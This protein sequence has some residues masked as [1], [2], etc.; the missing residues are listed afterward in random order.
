MRLIAIKLAGFKSFVE[1]VTLPVTGQMVGVVGP[2]GCGKSNVIDAVRW[3]LGESQARQLRGA[4]MA[5]VIFNGSAQRKAISR[6]SVELV[7]DNSTGRAFGN[8]SQYA[9]ISV[10]RVVT[11]QGDSTYYI[12]Q[13]AVRRRDVVDVFLGTG[14][15]GKSSYAIIEQGMITRIIE[16]RPEELRAFLEEAAGISRYKDRRRETE[17]RLEATRQNLLRVEDI[18]QTLL[19]QME[20]L[21]E[22]AETA[23]QWQQWQAELTQT[24]QLSWL[25]KQREA[26]QE[27]DRLVVLKQNV[28]Q[29]LTI[30]Q[31]A[32]QALAHAL[33]QLMQAQDDANAALNV[34]QAAFYAAGSDV[35]A[36]EQSLRH[37]QEIRTRVLA[38][39]EQLTLQE[40]AWQERQ[41][42]LNRD[43]E[44]HETQRVALQQTLTEQRERVQQQQAVL[45][46][47]E[48]AVRSARADVTERQRE[49]AAA[50]KA[51]E[52]AEAQ[53]RMLEK[54]RLQHEAQQRR[55][56]EEETRWQGAESGADLSMMQQHLALVKDKFAQLEAG[57]RTIQEELAALASA[58]DKV[59]LQCEASARDVHRLEGELAALR[60]LE[61]G[62]IRQEVAQWLTKHGLAQS[63][64]LLQQLEV[65]PG[66]ETALEQA[67]TVWLQTLLLERHNIPD[68]APQG[69]GW[70]DIAAGIAP[71]AKETHD[72]TTPDL[73]T[74]A[75]LVR[76]DASLRLLIEDLLHHCYVAETLSEARQLR[77]RLPVG[78]RLFTRQGHVLTQGG[79]QFP[80]LA[81]G[82]GALARQKALQQMEGDL[83]VMREIWQ[84][85]HRQQAEFDAHRAE[86]ETT[87]QD[88]L[89][90][91]RQAQQQ[92]HQQQLALQKTQ[93]QAE[94]RDLRLQQLHGERILVQQA[95]DNTLSEY[96]L[97]KE[98]RETQQASLA[99]HQQALRSAQTRLRENEMRQNEARTA[100]AQQEKLVQESH[101]QQRLEE[102]RLAE[103]QRSLQ[104]MAQQR[105]EHLEQRKQLETEQQ[106]ENDADL[107]MRLQQAL[108]QRQAAEQSLG[109]ARLQSEAAT[110]TWRD[111]EESR[112]VCQQAILPLQAQ[113]EQL[114]LQQQACRMT[115]EQS[116]Q[117]LA[118]LA[119]EI[120]LLEPLLNKAREPALNSQIKRLRSQ[121]EALGA[122]NLAAV[123]ELEAAR[124]RAEYLASQT[125]DLETGM[126]TLEAVIQ[127][128]DEETN[129]LFQ[130]T[131]D[132]VN[133]SMGELFQTL[134]GGGQAKLTLTDGSWLEAGVE[135][136]AQPPGKKNS[137]I[138]LLSG[139]E[140]T[141]TALS[142]VFALFKLNPAPFCLL[143]EVDAPLDDSNTER[144]VRLI[145]D[146][147][148]QTQFLF[149]THNRMTMEAAQQLLGVT[150]QEPGVSRIVAVDLVDAARMVQQ[151]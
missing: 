134:F 124:E 107:S 128:L 48:Q 25:L 12:N 52:L 29:T 138:Q 125:R 9:E 77:Y 116:G 112:L 131:F 143:D 115:A 1:P 57:G 14:L 94:H 71:V 3:A 44:I 27:H 121:I 41:A 144:Y 132:T 140:K 16:A 146:M 84:Q 78:G 113:L 33:P 141:L 83:A 120:S 108:V 122:V 53:L 91:S 68:E 67:L 26:E 130:Q 49:V 139:G 11:R 148:Q 72:L 109:K 114:V 34:A 117:M 74:L 36:L 2:N 22:Q 80:S 58:R 127:R 31:D 42:T 45:P 151:A 63:P 55:L 142:L 18:R 118:E 97:I 13:Q 98:Q 85:A 10:K 28:E 73:T 145:R 40:Q 88:L 17:T 51:I 75:E 86:L 19:A 15:G 54:S 65:E 6:A 123:A 119:A 7:F 90:E 104:Q 103:I 4:N 79:E 101:Y 64:R 135:V 70:L 82:Q 35:S 69:F 32:L 56:Q 102:N 150:M 87:R 47:L 38:Q 39:L 99:V 8:W 62:D 95:L 23:K 111:N 60:R 46:G 93:Q 137:S 50:S 136:M 24:Q 106:Q 133:T 89:L 20:H 30:Q 81:E 61:T 37:R 43:V 110:R 66:W 59:S 126:A 129:T 5:D 105:T 76:C 100:L 149:I 92:S 21:R 96:Q 147:S